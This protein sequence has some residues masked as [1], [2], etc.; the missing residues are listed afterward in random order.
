[1]D[2][3]RSEGSEARALPRGNRRSLLGHSTLLWLGDTRP[4]RPEMLPTRMLPDT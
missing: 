1:M 3:A 4:L 2:S